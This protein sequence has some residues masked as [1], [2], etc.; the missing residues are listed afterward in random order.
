MTASNDKIRSEIMDNIGQQEK[1]LK[2]ESAPEGAR[3]KRA[4][5]IEVSSKALSERLHTLNAVITNRI[6]MSNERSYL[7]SSVRAAHGAL[8]MDSL[9]RSMTPILT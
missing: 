8:L 2:A 9:L 4:D 7:A 5:D 3:V 1:K 6:I